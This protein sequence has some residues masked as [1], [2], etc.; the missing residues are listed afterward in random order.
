MRSVPAPILACGRDTMPRSLLEGRQLCSMAT[1][2]VAWMLCFPL[3]SGS[4][5]RAI[6]ISEQ[7]MK[8][9]VPRNKDIPGAGTKSWRLVLQVRHSRAPL[10]QIALIECLCSICSI[11]ILATCLY[12]RAS[13]RFQS[14]VSECDRIASRYKLART[15]RFHET[16]A[17]HLMR[18]VAC[19][20]LSVYQR[21]S[22]SIIC[23]MHNERTFPSV[24][25]LFTCLWKS[26]TTLP[27]DCQAGIRIQLGNLSGIRMA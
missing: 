4:T 11:Y 21:P 12:T 3:F 24:S 20:W 8:C 18:T 14:R 9:Y 10:P 17:R 6:N 5:R 27:Q 26:R 15:R 19:F 16:Q 2:A 13:D 25:R 22:N 23:G 1:R 7:S